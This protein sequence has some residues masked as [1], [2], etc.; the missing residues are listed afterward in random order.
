MQYSKLR[1]CSIL[2]LAGLLGSVAFHALAFAQNA[3]STSYSLSGQSSI[4]VEVPPN[5]FTI[6]QRDVHFELIQPI[7][8]W[9]APWRVATITSIR[10]GEIDA[11]QHRVEV[12]VD[13][14]SATGKHRLSAFS[15]KGSIGK[16]IGGD[17]IVITQLG[18][19]GGL[20]QHHVYNSI[21][22][23]KLFDSTGGWNVG[24][25]AWIKVGDTERWAAFQDM[26]VNSNT[27]QSLI[28]YVRYGAFNGVMSVVAFHMDPAQQEP[29]F[30]QEFGGCGALVWTTERRPDPSRCFD[31]GS[32][33]LGV[34]GHG[35]APVNGVAVELS[36]LGKVYATIPVTND[37]LDIAHATLAPGVTLVP[38]E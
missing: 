21:T 27:D 38:G 37:R 3:K 25:A 23:M 8:D 30:T 19:C 17:F 10:D 9:G 13:E 35:D 28:G 36:M 6:H 5:G 33:T 31:G 24:M 7:R 15:D 26:W 2:T 20:T 29:G 32:Y 18:C 34:P 22:G 4:T 12:T 16:D 1:S 11:Q 14:L